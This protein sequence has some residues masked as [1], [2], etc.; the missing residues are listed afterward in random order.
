[1]MSHAEIRAA[2]PALERDLVFLENAGGSQLP[3]AV[4]SGMTDYMTNSY[5]QLGAP[6]EVSRRATSVVDEAH[7]WATTLMGGTGAGQTAIGPSTTQLVTMLA[8]CFRRVW[9]PG[10]EVII[11]ETAHEANAGPWAKLEREGINVRTWRVDPATAQCDLEELRRML[12]SGT[13][14]VAFPH[15][16]NLLGEVV[17]VASITALAHEYGARVMVDGVAYAPHLAVQ[18]REWDVDWYVFSNYKVFGPHAAML[19][20]RHDAWAELEGPNHFF[21]P[22]DEVYK[23]ELGGA[24]HE[25]CAGI[26]AL[27]E[28]FRELTSAPGAPADEFLVTRAFDNISTIEKSL[29]SQLVNGLAGIPGIR[30]VGPT[31]TENR[32]GTVSFLHERVSPPEICQATDAAGVAIRYG[33]MYAYRLCQALGIPL[34]TGVVR[35]SLVHYNSHEDID[36]LLDVVEDAVRT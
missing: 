2:F 21:I 8:D 14:L 18:A 35:A 12:S 31:S 25:S 10:D 26:L 19:Y 13:R 11:C 29:T 4:I 28:Y 20:G 9:Q 24:N 33:H 1:M 6:Y 7:T 36:R 23:F 5:V 22:R 16:S 3:R 15:V 34:E 32:V 27:A 17:D 30:I